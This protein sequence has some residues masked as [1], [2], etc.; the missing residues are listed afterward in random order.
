[1]ERLKYKVLATE[2]EEMC[3]MLEVKNQ[4]FSFARFLVVT[5]RLAPTLI[6]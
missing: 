6:D 2:K 5:C 4:N 3:T 1:M